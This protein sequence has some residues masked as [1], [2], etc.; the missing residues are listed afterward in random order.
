MTDGRQSRKASPPGEPAAGARRIEKMGVYCLFDDMNLN[1][2]AGSG[3]S[4]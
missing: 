3:Q 4:R 1:R 2:G